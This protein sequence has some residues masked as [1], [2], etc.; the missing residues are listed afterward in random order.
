LAEKNYSK[1]WT[2]LC[3]YLAFPVPDKW[4]QDMLYKLNLPVIYAKQPALKTRC[5][6]WL[7]EKSGF[8]QFFGEVK[9]IEELIWTL[10]MHKGNPIQTSHVQDFFQ[11]FAA[12]YYQ[13]CN[14]SNNVDRNFLAQAHK[15]F[16]DS[17]CDYHRKLFTQ[18]SSTAKLN[19]ALS[20]PRVIL[21]LL[22]QIMAE[23]APGNT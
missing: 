7:A 5:L 21:A 2:E 17:R 13:F 6:E 4:T 22:R 15:L 16:V 8:P 10:R 12:Q 18:D 20:G 3:D 11:R 1:I 14:P 9:P 23:A 19:C